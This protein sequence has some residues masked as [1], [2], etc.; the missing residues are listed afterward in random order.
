MIRIVDFIWPTLEDWD[1]SELSQ[2]RMSNLDDVEAI[3]ASQWR[4]H[5]EDALEEARR[6]ASEEDERRRNTENKAS[7]YL[8]V[9]A[10]LVPLLTY[11]EDG[12]WQEKLGTAPRWLSL[13]ILMIAIL[14]LMRAGLWAFRVL[15][16]G[17][18]A[19]LDANSLIGAWKAPG[20]PRP[21]LIREILTA[22]RYNRGITNRKVSSIK[23]AHHFIV[24]VFFIFGILLLVEGTWEFFNSF[25]DHLGRFLPQTPIHRPHTAKPAGAPPE[26]T[27]ECRASFRAT[28]LVCS[29]FGSRH[30]PDARQAK[31]QAAVPILFPFMSGTGLVRRRRATFR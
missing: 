31:L 29:S 4:A 24:R 11:L 3:Q 28:G 30:E 26:Q 19:R 8:L 9:C 10:A 7:T 20:D 27:T 14:Y 18:F 16:V 21:R 22:E 23:M 12:I 15:D 17:S 6:I 1:P 5:S 2:E 13:P 25:S